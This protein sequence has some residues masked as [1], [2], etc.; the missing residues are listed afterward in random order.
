MKNFTKYINL[1][2]LTSSC[3]EEIFRTADSNQCITNCINS[4][5]HF[6]PFPDRVSG[7]CCDDTNCLNNNDYCSFNA[8]IRNNALKYWACPTDPSYCGLEDLLVARGDISANIRPK[9]NSQSSFNQG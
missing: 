9:G 7:V 4:N 3:A 5:N 6:C 8:P 1:W 2:L